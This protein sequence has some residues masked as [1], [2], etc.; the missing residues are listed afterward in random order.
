[1]ALPKTPFYF[2][3]HGETDWNRLRRCIGQQ[4]RFLNE[5]GRAQAQD[6]QR[7][8]ASLSVSAVFHSPLSRAAETAA[9]IAQDRRWPLVEVSALKEACLGVKEGAIEDDPSDPFILRWFAGA[10]IEGAETYETLG[11]RIEAAVADCLIRSPTA[12]PPLIVGHSASYRALRE[13]MGRPLTEV[14]HC[15]PYLHRPTDDGWVIEA[16][17]AVRPAQ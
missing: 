8:C 6:A 9:I 4:D 10:R 13:R 3:R 11:L 14:L 16:V 1:M 7:L 2:L 5:R 17:G 15:T 12:A